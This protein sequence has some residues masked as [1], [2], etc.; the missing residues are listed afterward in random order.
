MIRLMEQKR[1][2][3]RTRLTR[4][5]L[6]AAGAAI[7]L[8][9][10]L[11]MGCGRKETGRKHATI[12]SG[13]VQSQHP[14]QSTYPTARPSAVQT[15]PPQTQDQPL[16][17]DP[18]RPEYKGENPQWTKVR[19]EWQCQ[20]NWHSAWMEIP[21]DVQ[22]YNYYHDLGRYYGVENY[23][24]YI[25]DENNQA[26]VRDLV[27]AMQDVAQAYAYDDAAVAREIV[28]FVQD[29]I[30]YQYDDEGTGQEEYPKYPIETLYERRGDC[31]DSSILMAALLREWGYEVGFLQLPQHV[32]VAIRTTDT[33]AEGPYYEIDGHRYLFIESTG[34]G[35]QIGAIPE[36]FSET[37][38]K[39]YRIP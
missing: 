4:R 30:E 35:W 17:Y 1:K 38:A 13:S 11:L 16:V 9:V 15:L 10:P 26:I 18:R 7:C 21:L 31:E 3:E 23:Y 39:L 36:D 20:D 24:L 34:S 22:M 29:C 2:T 32:A 28:K 19:F 12:R 5:E 25:Q 33:Y 37:G 8:A 14:T 27:D 6:A